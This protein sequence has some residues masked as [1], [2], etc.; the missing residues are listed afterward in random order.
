MML[1]PENIP[2]ELKDKKIWT[3]ID[4]QKHSFNPLIGT[5]SSADSPNTLTDFQS[6]LN[7]VNDGVYPFLSFSLPEGYTVIEIENCYSGYDYNDFTKELLERCESYAEEMESG[8]GLR[9]ICK[10]KST[11]SFSKSRVYKQRIN[12]YSGNRLVTI[13]GH[14]LSDRKS[15]VHCQSF[16]DQ[17]HDEEWEYR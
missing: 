2:Q 12:V 17:I 13:T 6:C 3:C 15:I 8:F 7:A 14:V 16:I 10:G 4:K 1:Y 5:S 11:S 9:I